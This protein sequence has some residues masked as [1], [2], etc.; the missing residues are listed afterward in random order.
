MEALVRHV[1]SPLLSHPDD[2]T[3]N[4]LEGRSATVLEIMVHEDDKA[5][6]TEDDEQTLRSARTVLSAAAGKRKATIELV[7]AFSEL[8]EEAED[9]DSEDADAEDDDSEESDD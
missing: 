9:D 2:L 4:V 5:V 6:L 1:L 8:E 7:E 3:V